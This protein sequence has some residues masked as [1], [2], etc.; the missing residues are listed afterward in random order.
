MR[1]KNSVFHQLQQHIPW[2]VFDKLVDEHKADHRVRRLDTKGQF[3]ALL[4]GQLAGAKSLREIEVGLLSQKTRL[5]H[6]GARTVAR[7][8]LADANAKRPADLFSDLFAHMAA[9]A[10]RRTRR[11]MRDSVRLIDATRIRLSSVFGGW[12][13]MIGG[14]NAIKV[15][16][17][18]DPFADVPLNA[19]I[20][21]QKT[22]DIVPARQTEIIPGVT[23]VF[24]LAY[25]DFGWWAKIDQCGARF[26]TRLKTNTTVTLS[27]QTR[28]RR[29]RAKQDAIVSDAIGQLPQRMASSRQNPFQKPVR[30]VTVLLKT[31][32]TLR[33]VTNDLDAPA[34]EIAELYKQRWQI[35]LFFKWIKQNLNIRHFLGRSENAVR[36]QIFVALIAHILLR[37]AQSCQTSI[38]QPLAFTRLVR[39]TIMERRALTALKTIPDPPPQDPRQ[40]SF[41]LW[42]S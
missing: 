7:T 21:G 6:V 8:T 39:L 36:I 2:S 33:L 26:V 12:A 11:H 4:F 18:Y 1:H 37:L 24:D 28:F 30:V 31:G 16:L 40:M 3:L 13:D 32:K 34:Q 27:Q 22:N 19:K 14:R 5:Y 29:P 10:S 42:P 25:Y 9:T 15:H 41:P 23:Y 35:E 17:T 20:T 38:L